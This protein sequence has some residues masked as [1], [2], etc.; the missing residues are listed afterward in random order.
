MRENGHWSKF[1]S[2]HCYFKDLFFE[3]SMMT[4]KN[5]ARREECNGSAFHT[6]FR[7]LLFAVSSCKADPYLHH[8][9]AS[10]GI[11]VWYG[12]PSEELVQFTCGRVVTEPKMWKF[13]S[14][15]RVFY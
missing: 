3:K 10:E 2:F 8:T 1:S 7:Q 4:W 11:L 9:G 15:I 12:Q 6:N 13:K 5:E 14:Q